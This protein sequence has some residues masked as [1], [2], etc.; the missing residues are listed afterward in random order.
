MKY[1]LDHCGTISRDDI[2][3]KYLCGF[4]GKDSEEFLKN[5][6]A[7]RAKNGDY[8]F[9]DV[10]GVDH[11]Y[12]LESAAMAIENGTRKREVYESGK[13]SWNSIREGF[14]DF[15]QHSAEL[16][17]TIYIVSAGL[18]DWLD[19]YWSNFNNR[20]EILA[21]ELGVDDNGVYERIVVPVGSLGKERIIRALY[22]EGDRIVCAGDSYRGDGR[23]FE[24]VRSLG[25]L[26]IGFGERIEGDINFPSDADWV[27]FVAASEMFREISGEG[28]ARFP[29]GY[30]TRVMEANSPLGDTVVKQLRRRDKI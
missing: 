5:V 1:A 6:E 15:I 25:G 20:P 28:P 30:D 29:A 12:G 14:L 7:M 18:A 22:N 27:P 4:W 3:A 8:P 16:E 23:M 9:R 19:A 24:R 13:Q 17:D 11:E 21:T 26:T 10:T 2:G